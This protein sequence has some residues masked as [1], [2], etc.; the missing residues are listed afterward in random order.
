MPTGAED[1][2]I[3][4]QYDLHADLGL[5]GRFASR[6]SRRTAAT[7]PA[8]MESDWQRVEIYATFMKLTGEMEV[9]RPD[10]LSDAINRTGDYVVLRRARTEPLSVNFPVLS[11]ETTVTTVARQS[12]VLLCPLTDPHDRSGAMWREKVPCP[13]SINCHAFSMVG[14]VHL[15]PQ[16]SLEDHLDRNP[17]DFL[18]VT[19][20]SALWVASLG[21]ETH[22]L[23]RHFALLNPAAILSF[24]LR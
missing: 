7:L 18:P 6:H 12:I 22:S 11:R 4:A 19:N 9:V 16:R 13:A 17:G 21:T 2:P 1:T 8:T 3:E 10:R 5:I 14:D 23:Q 15:E 20:L 24:S